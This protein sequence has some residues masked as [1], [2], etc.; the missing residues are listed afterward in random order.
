MSHLH[1][2]NRPL[3]RL[4]LALVLV[5]GFS[6]Y[7]VQAQTSGAVAPEVTQ[8]E[9]I[10]MTDLV[11]LSSGDFN[12]SIPV[13]SLPGAPGGAFPIGLSYQSG[14]KYDQ[15][16]TWVGLGWNL[17]LGQV[18]RVVRGIPD[19]LLGGKIISESKSTSFITE[20][21]GFGYG[22]FSVGLSWDN[23][24]G[25]GGSVG[26]SYSNTGLGRSVSY[27]KTG[28]GD[29]EV[30]STYTYG[31]GGASISYNTSGSYSAGYSF[32]NTSISYNSAQDTGIDIS[33]SFSKNFSYSTQKSTNRSTTARGAKITTVSSTKN[34]N[35]YYFSFGKSERV[36]YTRGI[37]DAYGYMHIGNMGKSKISDSVSSKINWNGITWSDVIDTNDD[38]MVEVRNASENIMDKGI[39]QLNTRNPQFD[40]FF[41]HQKGLYWSSIFSDSSE[42]NTPNQITYESKYAHPDID[43]YNVVAQGIVG[44]LRPLFKNRSTAYNNDDIVMR[45]T[46]NGSS[47]DAWTFLPY[48]NFMWLLSDAKHWNS[49]SSQKGTSWTSYRQQLK[50]LF[51][52]NDGTIKDWSL[53]SDSANNEYEMVLLEDSGLIVTDRDYD[54]NPSDLTTLN[55]YRELMLFSNPETG[56]FEWDNN[57][58]DAHIENRSTKIK[59]ALND[60]GQITTITITR[61]DG[62]VYIFG[63]I[64]GPVNHLKYTRYDDSIPD[65]S[66]KSIGAISHNLSS[67]KRNISVRTVL[68]QPN[69]TGVD[70]AVS[71]EHHNEPSGYAW[72]LASILAPDYVDRGDRGPSP[73]DFGDYLKV[74][75]RQTNPQ[76]YW[77]SPISVSHFDSNK[78]DDVI[79]N[80]YL[81][82]GKSLT[83]TN[84]NFF[85]E[86]GSKEIIMPFTAETKSHVAYFDIDYQNSRL[87]GLS[88]IGVKKI[89]SVHSEPTTG[90]TADTR[91]RDHIKFHAQAFNILFDKEEMGE[92][93]YNNTR[94]SFYNAVSEIIDGNLDT[95]LSQS[96]DPRTDSDDQDAAVISRFERA[97]LFTPIGLAERLSLTP[98]EEITGINS[99]NNTARDVGLRADMTTVHSDAPENP[100]LYL[101][102]VSY[103]DLSVIYIG[104]VE[105]LAQE[106][107]LITKT[108]PILTLISDP[109]DGIYPID[110]LTAYF[111]EYGRIESLE[112]NVPNILSKL[113]G[114][115]IYQYDDFREE[116]SMGSSVLLPR[117]T[118]ESLTPST[119]QHFKYK[120]LN[121]P[122]ETQHHLH[123][124]V[125]NYD[126]Q[127]AKGTPNT[128]KTYNHPD[129]ETPE[130]YNGERLTLKN[131]Q[132]YSNFKTGSPI[133][134]S[135]LTQ[136]EVALNNGYKFNYFAES[137]DQNADELFHPGQSD[138]IAWQRKFTDIR[139]LQPWHKDA[140]GYISIPLFVKE[141]NGNDL[142]QTMSTNSRSVVDISHFNQNLNG[143]PHYNIPVQA[144]WNLASIQTPNGSLLSIDYEL[145]SYTWVQDLPAIVKNAAFPYGDAWSDSVPPIADPDSPFNISAEKSLPFS[146]PTTATSTRLST[147]EIINT[148]LTYNNGTEPAS[149]ED[150]QNR[151]IDFEFDLAGKTFWNHELV[152]NNPD[153]KI[154][155]L[156]VFAEAESSRAG[157]NSLN[158]YPIPVR[159]VLPIFVSGTKAHLMKHRAL[160]KFAEWIWQEEAHQRN[161]QAADM[162][163]L[164]FYLI[165]KPSATE[166]SQWATHY[167]EDAYLLSHTNNNHPV[168]GGVPGYFPYIYLHQ[169]IVGEMGGGLRTKSL[170]MQQNELVPNKDGAYRITYDYNY[171]SGIGKGQS[172]GTIFSDPSRGSSNTKGD[173]EDRRIVRSE[174]NPYYNMTNDQVYYGEVTTTLT[175][176]N[177]TENTF[178]SKSKYLFNTANPLYSLKERYVTHPFNADMFSHLDPTEGANE[179]TFMDGVLFRS[180]NDTFVLEGEGP[181]D[182]VSAK[183]SK[184]LKW[185]LGDWYQN[186]THAITNSD[187]VRTHDAYFNFDVINAKIIVNNHGFIGTLKQKI[188]YAGASAT[189]DNNL[190]DLQIST[191]TTHTYAP[192]Y[193][194]M[195]SSQVPVMSFRNNAGKLESFNNDFPQGVYLQKTAVP[196]ISQENYADENGNPVEPRRDLHRVRVLLMDEVFNNFRTV[197]T[198]ITSFDLDRVD[199]S[200][201][202]IE[203]KVENDTHFLAFDLHTGQPVLKATTGG[204]MVHSDENNTFTDQKDLVFTL[205]VPAHYLFTPRTGRSSMFQR[206]MLNQSGF[207]AIFNVADDNALQ[208]VQT[209]IADEA[210][211]DV[212]DLFTPP[213]DG[214]PSPN[215]FDQVQF[216]A[217]SFTAWKQPFEN[218]HIAKD[219]TVAVGSFAFIPHQ[220]DVYSPDW[221]TIPT[222]PDDPSASN[223]PFDIVNPAADDDSRWTSEGVNT[224]YND[225]LVVTEHRTRRN[226]YSTVL[227][228]FDQR[229]PAALFSHA[230]RDQVFHQSFEE[231]ENPSTGPQ[232]IYINTQ[233]LDNFAYTDTPYINAEGESQEHPYI[234]NFDKVYAGVRS[235]NLNTSLYAASLNTLKVTDRDLYLQFFFKPQG[236]SPSLS[237]SLASTTLQP[238]MGQVHTPTPSKDY[239]F[240]PVENGWWFFKGSFKNFTNL[241]SLLIS[242]TGYIDEVTAYPKGRTPADRASQSLQ[243]LD[244]NVITYGYHPFTR[245]LISQTGTNGRTV[246]YE[247]NAKGE[248]LRTFD[249]D[250]KL[251]TENFRV[252]LN[253]PIQSAATPVQD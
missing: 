16:A 115:K 238:V 243:E 5:A 61:Q 24:G 228:V 99:A 163:K 225:H 226:I 144:A 57:P 53:Y 43:N 58:T 95:I 164:L 190:L 186:P 212:L 33:S 250:G 103:T 252:P 248:L 10:D 216:G 246:R 50:D 218:S 101:T 89:H 207:Q 184:F 162:N 80:K 15:E 72:H 104:Y 205:D 62:L 126:Y 13:A 158:P 84:S 41:D 9:P 136:Q 135:Q 224:K 208:E 117:G 129:W 179:K 167:S 122:D 105:H 143:E 6:K 49:K 223:W 219:S 42:N 51:L 160:L 150:I 229:Y 26:Y 171:T 97:L 155:Y 210:A 222:L 196:L 69:P 236:T 124:V 230:K 180:T 2:L 249:I 139:Y 132:F 181:Q 100:D 64:D 245:Q 102:F 37:A 118:P 251:R 23:Y 199:Q 217:A 173:F 247:Y 241:G 112:I 70:S 87:D 240:Y 18:T 109:P 36:T 201:N 121:A 148:T 220:P 54:M 79:E 71:D 11:N 59:Y 234:Q 239:G 32:G 159:F 94:D 134:K 174:I 55:R 211:R 172:S 63:K 235:W 169:N 111:K 133:D 65:T 31:T 188:D 68:G 182:G 1:I 29:T 110:G 106:V 170:T 244:A 98:G 7:P 138:Y 92:T 116:H 200:G 191:I 209:H 204:R 56:D 130:N 152:E 237:V 177:T 96:I 74:T 253:Q 168:F 108:N 12:Y 4:S 48:R 183:Q 147:S 123:R 189:D 232:T 73:D 214:N 221:R 193:N 187:Q 153:T 233:W 25:F 178:V 45:G 21:M 39:N 215:H 197:K 146:T 145:D 165:P 14:I 46:L 166:G 60:S 90:L 120:A 19:D 128:L 44:S 93:D 3:T 141:Q 140:W 66:Y 67:Y 82:M 107:Y 40:F 213:T 227:H 22:G 142:F 78:T 52:N 47:N 157:S 192:S 131:V 206:N 198:T 151:L 77:E 86:H 203:S 156:I 125:F 75:Y 30:S 176:L 149:I 27:Y 194:P 202:P 127:L 231:E 17:S 161:G 20:H 76:Y 34:G 28:A 88:T 175:P 154:S 35:F 195:Q 114:I 85:W 38:N 8:F 185:K 113:A 83:N 242:G 81:Y 137:N 119:L 91:R